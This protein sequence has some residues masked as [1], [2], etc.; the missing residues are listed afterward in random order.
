MNDQN[1]EALDAYYKEAA[2]W[3]RDRLEA[4]RKSQRV[5]W[6]I[7]GGAAAIA[8]LLALALML[9]TPLKTVEPY[10]LLVDRTT[11][12]VQAVNPLEANKISPETALTQSF[13]VQYVV[14]RESF[15]ISTLRT[16]HNKVALWSADRAR[17]DYLTV[18]QPSNPQNP[19]SLYPRTTLVE[20]RVKSVSPI[21]RNVALVRFD[22]IRQDQGG[23]FQSPRSWVAVIRYRYSGEPMRLEDRFVNPLGF[24]VLRY[25][26]DPETSPPPEIVQVPG[27][28]AVVGV[29][30]VVPGGPTTTTTTTTVEQQGATPLGSAAAAAARAAA[31]RRRSRAPEP[32]L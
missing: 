10:T 5:A 26:K 6:W 1:R 21:G 18:M 11:G 29:P 28:T 15:D 23:Q 30:V 17:S 4:L 25:R 20:T 12:F 16:Y 31:E 14:A 27:Q 7:A 32:E 2:T 3:N 24:Q 19:L 22:T 9:L 8:V 13:L